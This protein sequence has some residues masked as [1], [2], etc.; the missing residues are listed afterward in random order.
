LAQRAGSRV[1]SEPSRAEPLFRARQI[2]EPRRAFVSIPTRAS[3]TP[4]PY[5]KSAYRRRLAGKK[6]NAHEWVP[7]ARDRERKTKER[8]K[9][10]RVGLAQ[11]ARRG[12]S[13]WF[14]FFYFKIIN[15]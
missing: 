12:T 5:E 8:K 7:P 9:N 2:D 14:P 13:G 3:R 6:R 11:M 1:R 15:S 4:D 10:V